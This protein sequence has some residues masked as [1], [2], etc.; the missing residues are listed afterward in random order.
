[1]KKV[2]LPIFCQPFGTEGVHARLA[3]SDLQVV[4][5]TTHKAC[6][7]ITQYLR[8]RGTEDELTY[9][10]LTRYEFHQLL[11]PITPGY[12]EGNKLYPLPQAVEV[13]I[14]AISGP[15]ETGFFECLLPQIDRGFY[16][17]KPGERDS[18]IRHF[19][20]NYLQ[21]LAPSEVFAFLRQDT[22]WLEEVPF[23]LP[24][25]KP[26]KRR[27]PQDGLEALQVLP[28]TAERLPQ[29]R[30]P[31]QI[32]PGATWEREDEVRWV[33]QELSEAGR[34]VLLVGQD[35]VGKDAILLEAIRR[36]RREEQSQKPERPTTFWRTRSSRITAQARYLGEWQQICEGL[37][38]ELVWARG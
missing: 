15:N 36:I 4:A 21:N 25:P 30:L 10:D 33:M 12:R 24:K 31:D 26:P 27:R 6:D 32:L 35:G 3:G 18:L 29:P 11:L 14:Y 19:S 16:Y 28:A 17:Y 1:M 20:R 5:G 13:P 8:R 34:Q 23:R 2:T 22:A 7:L 37:V 9:L 38:Q